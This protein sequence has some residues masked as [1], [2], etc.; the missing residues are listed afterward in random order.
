M[1]MTPEVATMR[2][3]EELRR[4]EKSLDEALMRQSELLATMLTARMMASDEPF[5]GQAEIL[6]LIK[7]QQ[8]ITASANDLARVHG[9][10]LEIGRERNLIDECPE[11]RR[12]S[13]QIKTAA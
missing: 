3:T 11:E 10:L 13:G 2:I 4:A 12:I 6:R 1:T 5:S 7:A 9:G 8:A